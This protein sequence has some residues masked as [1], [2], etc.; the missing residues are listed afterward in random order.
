MA[1][2]PSPAP[3]GIFLVDT[4]AEGLP[5]AVRQMSGAWASITTQQ[6]DAYILSGDV[7]MATETAWANLGRIQ[8]EK[9]DRG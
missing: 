4:G 3:D 9:G 5:V 8:G 6:G 2:L 1:S 7:W